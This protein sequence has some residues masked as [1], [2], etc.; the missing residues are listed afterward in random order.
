MNLK[1]FGLIIVLM[2]I[3]LLGIIFIQWHFI[4]RTLQLN[5][6]QFNGHVI[7]ALKHVANKIEKEEEIQ[8][9]RFDNGFSLQEFE[10]DTHGNYT[11]LWISQQVLTQ[12]NPLKRKMSAAELKLALLEQPLEQRLDL[13]LLDRLL[14]FEL[15]EYNVRIP[16]SYGVY[17]NHAK[18]LIAFNN[19]LLD[20]SDNLEDYVSVSKSQYHVAL[21]SSDPSMPFSPGDLYLYFPNK[22]RYVWGSAGIS[23][24]LS[25]FFVLLI[26]A[27]FGYTVSVIL[28]Q[29]K[30]SEMKTDFVNNM[31]HE[32]K[33]PIATISL[34]ADSITSASI[35]NNPDKIRRFAGIIS[36]ENK[37]MN[38]QV[39]KVLQMAQLDRDAIHLNLTEVDLHEI[40][41]HAVDNISLQV[42]KRDGVVTYDLKAKNPIVEGDQNHIANIINNLLDNANK[43]SPEKPIISVTT[44][45]KS[46]GVE[47]TVS[48]KGMGISKESRKQ[49]FEKFFR[50]HTGNV[51]DIKGFG[52][53]LAYVKAMVTAHNGT[54]DLKS[55][56]GKGSSFTLF[57]PFKVD[58]KMADI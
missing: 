39:E 9:S 49:I 37:R 41:E 43:Y 58:L 22:D 28:K 56:I 34:A 19:R 8:T 18:K 17:S 24:F 5:E 27:C 11:H 52:L 10:R 57:F 21:L 13:P 33:T 54:I 4:S 35:I 2:F 38:G 25:A 53:G 12:R 1:F 15:S 50:V 29:K 20:V 55:D 44:V 14:K 16:Y 30:L 31:T 40:I 36:A 3:A 32:F 46:K 47:V 26:L 42:H 51:H 7:N 48:D 23:V 45:S 6:Q